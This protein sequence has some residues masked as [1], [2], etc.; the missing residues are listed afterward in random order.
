MARN[1]DTWSE[2]AW[3]SRSW[4]LD[5]ISQIA[6]RVSIVV[7]VIF[8][9]GNFYFSIQSNRTSARNS[10]LQSLQYIQKFIDDDF[11][12]QSLI[13]N[14]DPTQ[15]KKLEKQ[16]ES[17]T[18]RTLYFSKSL[19]D[20][21]VIGEHYERMG[22][23]VKQGYLDFD[24]IYEIIPFPDNFWRDSNGLRKLLRE[25]W[26]G[27]GHSLPDLWENFGYLCELYRGRRSPD[28]KYPERTNVKGCKD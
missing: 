19:G 13:N 24:L 17:H 16:V 25:K 1:R 23:E 28:P 9:V 18:G 4:N 3:E 10:K 14:L 5:R 6:T 11:K 20:V 15:F 27:D 12:I 8:A 22:A 26:D 2:D 21:S 7:G